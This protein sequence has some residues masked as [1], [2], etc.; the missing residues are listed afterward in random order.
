MAVVLKVA[1][2]G[3]VDPV[4]LA[5][6]GLAHRPWRAHHAESALLGA[7]APPAAFEGALALELAH[8]EPLRDNAY[9]VSL[10]RNLALDVLNRLTPAP[11][12]A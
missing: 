4:G 8:A 9:K 11:A 3:I 1:E 5:F 7:P 10:A 2:D 12:P 6:G